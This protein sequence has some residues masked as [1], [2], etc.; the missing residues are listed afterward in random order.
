M[1]PTQRLYGIVDTARDPMLFEWVKTVKEPRC[2]FIGAVPSPLD[3]AAPYLVSLDGEE[4]LSVWRRDGWGQSWGIMF[5]SAE[6]IDS[7]RAHFRRFLVCILP[8]GM[9]GFFRF[10]DPRV[11]RPYWLSLTPEE[12]SKWL[13]G[14]S[15]F[16]VEP[17]PV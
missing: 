14:I 12:R 15:E 11:W 17:A 10:Y 7:L 8:D 4:F 6:T 16:I 9:T 3:A 5:R 1:T 2:L 13:N